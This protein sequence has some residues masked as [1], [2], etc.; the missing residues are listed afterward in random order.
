MLKSARYLCKNLNKQVKQCKPKCGKAFEC[1]SNRPRPYRLK[2]MHSLHP[3]MR[4]ILAQALRSTRRALI[5][6]LSFEYFN[7][8]SDNG[9]AIKS[10]PYLPELTTHVIQKKCWFC[11]CSR[12]IVRLIR[13]LLPAGIHQGCKD[14]T[15]LYSEYLSQT[16]VRLISVPSLR[17][18]RQHHGWRW[19]RGAIATIFSQWR[20]KAMVAGCH[21]YDLIAMN[22]DSDGRGMPSLRSNCKDHR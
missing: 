2:H 11:L 3:F 17:S 9:T 8:S 16:I 4:L 22:T 18:Y 10:F 6:W 19:S 20:R 12:T 5:N 1:R 21:H 13:K 15:K 7:D 14:L